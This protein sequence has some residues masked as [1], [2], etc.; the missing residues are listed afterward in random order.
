VERRERIVEAAAFVFA[1]R[2]FDGATTNLIAA[3]AKVSEALL[4]RHF[5]SKSAIY[6]AV[7]QK[8]IRQQNAEIAPS[9][10]A[11]STPLDY[12]RTLQDY[13]AR[14]LD[15]RD[16]TEAAIGHRLLL[17]SLAGDG[18]YAKLIY[19]RV[20]RILRSRAAERKAGTSL[21]WTAGIAPANAM[22]FISYIGMMLAA[23]S[24]SGDRLV[25]Y[26]GDRDDILRDALLFCAR[27]L[28]LGDGLVEQLMREDGGQISP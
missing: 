22:F 15:M 8:L 16:G 6:R 13:L 20:L 17:A 18:Q 10:A 28:G 19:R 25:P 11:G 3:R 9:L 27:G 1:D 4:Y 23:T 12:L 14:G 24:V 26:A 5:K 7:L 2:G 21:D